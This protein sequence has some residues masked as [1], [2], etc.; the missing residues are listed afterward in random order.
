MK[1]GYRQVRRL[2]ARLG[3]EARYPKRFKAATD[4]NHNGAISPNGQNLQF[5]AEAPTKFGRLASPAPGLWKAGCI[6]RSSLICFRGKSWAGPLQATCGL[7]CVPVPC[8][9]PIYPQGTRAQKAETWL[10]PSFGS[11]QPICQPRIP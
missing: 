7:R 11:G 3:L 6:W 9:W 8:K 2:M 5:G 4:S 1:P 10:A